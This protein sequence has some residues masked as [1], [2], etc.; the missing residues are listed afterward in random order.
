MK[1]CIVQ[2][3]GKLPTVVNVLTKVAPLPFAPE[4]HRPPVLVVVCA[5]E[6]IQVHLTW[7]FTLMVTIVGLKKKSPIFTLATLVARTGGEEPKAQARS[8]ASAHRD[9]RAS[10]EGRD[11]FFM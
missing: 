6:P 7:S 2:L 4:S 1:G 3:Y 9:N 11:V 10:G 8:P 5:A